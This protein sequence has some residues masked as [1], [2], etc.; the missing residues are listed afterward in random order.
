M[1]EGWGAPPCTL[2]CQEGQ[3]Y[4]AQNAGGKVES[5]AREISPGGIMEPR[6]LY[7]SIDMGQGAT[8]GL[9]QRIMIWARAWFRMLPLE[10]GSKGEG[11]RS[12]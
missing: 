2:E 7:S 6:K 8:E 9:R 4:S 1:A 12:A 5:V 10:P 3:C 11:G